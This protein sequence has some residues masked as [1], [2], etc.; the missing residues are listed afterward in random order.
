MASI[1]DTDI[2][3]VSNISTK[4]EGRGG[5]PANVT[6]TLFCITLSW[7]RKWYTNMKLQ[8]MQTKWKQTDTCVSS[9][10]PPSLFFIPFNPIPHYA[11]FNPFIGRKEL[12]NWIH[13]K[14]LFYSDT[15]RNIIKDVK[16]S[17]TCSTFLL[18][19]KYDEYKSAAIEQNHLYVERTDN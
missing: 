4:K 18:L 14:K 12:K 16:G 3:T 6:L 1:T 5:L 9:A 10:P 2:K 15:I 11:V 13:T 8:K 7:H 19:L 17:T